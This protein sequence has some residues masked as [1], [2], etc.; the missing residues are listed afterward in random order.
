[1]TPT[2][3]GRS[4]GSLAIEQMGLYRVSDGSHTALAAAGAAQPGRVRR[5]PHHRRKAGA[6]GRARRGGGVFWVGDGEMPEIR[7]VAPG[8]AAA[9]NNWMGFRENGDYIVTGFSETPLLPALAA[10]LI[11]VGL[12]AAWRREGR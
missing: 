10:L 12:L 11:A 9:G 3:G 1:M 5:C 6:G 4:T 7:R 8:R 2:K